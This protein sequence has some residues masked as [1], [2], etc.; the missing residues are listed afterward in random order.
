MRPFQPYRKIKNGKKKSGKQQQTQNTKD[1][2]S[3]TLQDTISILKTALN[4]KQ[5]TIDTLILIIE[6]IKSGP[7]NLQ[8][9]L[10]PLE[11]R[12]KPEEQHQ[13]ELQSHQDDLTQQ[14]Q[15]DT[16]QDEMQQQHVSQ[17]HQ[18]HKERQHQTYEQQ[19]TCNEELI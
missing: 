6:K 19:L 1:L 16:W 2:I 17:E 18:Q 11:E 4:N 9:R 12:E 13:H 7:S 5:K 14:Q 10:T 8:A 15:L 3:E